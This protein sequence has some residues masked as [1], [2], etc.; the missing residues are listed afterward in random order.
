MNPFPP[1]PAALFSGRWIVRLLGLAL[2]LSLFSGCS[3]MNAR[4][5]PAVPLDQFKRF[6]V[7]QRLNDNHGIGERIAADLRARGYTAT[8]GHLTMMPDNTEVLITYDARWSWDFRSYLI[9][10][11]ITARR[12]YANAIIATGNYHH[13]GVTNKPPETMIRALLDDFFR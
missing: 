7:E 4:R 9:N 1:P 10:L 5:N 6:Y 3:T 13:P 8:C 2:L 12:A 11:D